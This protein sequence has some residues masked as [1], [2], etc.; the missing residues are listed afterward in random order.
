MLEFGIDLVPERVLNPFFSERVLNPIFSRFVFGFEWR[1]T[2][3]KV[4]TG[5]IIDYKRWE[6]IAA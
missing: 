5:S 1:T 4:S 2:T 6:L 3:M